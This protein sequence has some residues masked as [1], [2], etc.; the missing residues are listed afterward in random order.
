LPPGFQTVK[1]QRHPE[2]FQPLPPAPGHYPYRLTLE[3][4]LT[5]EA[6]KQIT[7]AGRLTFH[8]VGDTGGVNTPT[9]QEAVAYYVEQNFKR[10]DLPSRPSFFYHLGDVVYYDGEAENYYWEFYEPY[11]TYP[12]PIF[13]IPGNH[14][15][16]INPLHPPHYSLETFLRNFCAQMPRP[17]VD[18]RGEAPR[19]AMTQPNVYW[20]LLTPFGTLIGLYT[21]VPEGGVVDQPQQDWFRSELK[22]APPDKALIVALHHPVYSAYGPHPGSQHLKDFLDQAC[23][24]ANRTPHLVLSGHVHD[25]QRFSSPLHGSKVPFI[26]AGA[27]GYNKRLHEL[28]DE[29]HSAHLPLAMGEAG[30]KLEKFCDD[31]HGFLRLEV[32]PT[33]IKGEYV[34]VPDSIQRGGP[35]LEPF[36][37][38]TIPLSFGGTVD[39]GA[40][41]PESSPGHKSGKKKKK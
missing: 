19:D 7:D 2:K 36:E 18:T 8:T 40:A 5:D 13:A 16:D 22:A 34:A 10:P 27:G 23:A 38:F 3:T 39:P 11:L 20:T 12:A 25:Y 32:S 28:A 24:A 15:G 35:P 14:D 31:R 30:V 33:E 29:F 37:T 9:Y 6:M 41:H 4:I 1:D 26:V 21:N 17:S